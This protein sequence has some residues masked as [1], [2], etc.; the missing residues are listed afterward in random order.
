[1]RSNKLAR[2]SFLTCCWALGV[3]LLLSLSCC[4]PGAELKAPESTS[5]AP[6]SVD[7]DKIIIDSLSRQL[8]GGLS[9][10]GSRDSLIQAISPLMVG[11]PAERL[12]IGWFE[13]KNNW[14]PLFEDAESL[15]FYITYAAKQ[16]KEEG[17]MIKGARMLNAAARIYNMEGSYVR[18]AELSQQAYEIAHAEGDS[19]TMGWAQAYLAE[20]FIFGKDTLGAKVH[21]GRML[22]I[23][24]ALGDRGLEGNALIRIGAM[25]AHIG[26]FNRFVDYSKE[27]TTFGRAHSVKFV[28]IY[29]ILNTSI[30]LTQI[31]KNKE[32][33][34]L[35]RESSFLLKDGNAPSKA[36][37][38]FSLFENFYR[39]QD[40]EKALTYLNEAC[41]ISNQY[42]HFLGIG[43]CKE[44]TARLYE[45]REDPLAAL[46]AYKDYHDYYEAKVGA[47]AKQ[48]LKALEIQQQ[49]R[50]K[51]LEIERLERA[52]EENARIYAAK[53]RRTINFFLALLG[54]GLLAFVWFFSRKEI[55]IAQQ[56]KKIAEAKLEALRSQ[57]NP[58][59][60]F[61]ALNG[62][63]NF[64]LKSDKFEAYAYLSNFGELLRAITKSSASIGIEIEEEVKLLRNYLEMEK[65][66]FREQFNYEIIVD[67]ELLQKRKHLS[68]ISYK[69]ELKIVISPHKQGVKSIV[70]DNGRGREAAAKLAKGNKEKH[71]SIA[72]INI[73]ERLDFLREI[74]SEEAS[75][76]IEDLYKE[77]VSCGTAVTV[78]LPFMGK[79]HSI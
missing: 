17:G 42:G 44:S 26:D 74:G 54:V 24:K 34:A 73:Q 56:R 51:D 35:I 48:K 30:G 76:E 69:G 53:R 58:H 41:E 31:G 22:E 33:I 63:Q 10:E 59:F 20:P 79:E 68:L 25:Y 11:D 45:K 49:V 13:L 70:T 8:P 38:N 57:M 6:L 43:Y 52:E 16:V 29:G 39:L 46:A 2:L 36:L 4:G 28:E 75:I 71:L 64:I 15:L 1:M 23:G 66:R 67:P 72:S 3:A 62:V 55:S 18:G 78:Y 77:G 61:N 37:L 21:L 47:E 19:A 9:Q 60:I 50:N 7:F 12:F 14:I 5:Q 65:L 40:Y 27:A 32:S